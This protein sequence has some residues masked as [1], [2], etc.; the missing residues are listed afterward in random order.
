MQQAEMAVNHCFINEIHRIA[1]VVE[2]CEKVLSGGGR[3]C[4]IGAGT[5]GRLGVLDAAECPPTFGVPPNQIQAIMAG[6]TSAVSQASEASEDNPETGVRDLMTAGFT[7]RDVLIGITASGR[8]PY[9][10]GAIRKA[11]ELGAVTAGICCTADSELSKAVDLPIELLVGPEV[12][13][14]ST[15]LKAGTATKLALNMISTATMVRMG[16]VYGNLMVNVQPKN[17]K[18][19]DRARRIIAQVTGVPY[20]RAAELLEAAGKNVKTAIVMEK[21]G[22]DRIAAESRLTQAGGR[23]REA[24][25]VG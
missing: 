8:T 15:R 18:L 10:L 13:A 3:I 19:V 11:R 14:G 17:E 16:H 23:I 1:K 2:A 6:G 9:V 21:L 22:L 4:Y 7:G 20:E 24:L 12:V 5:S 25:R